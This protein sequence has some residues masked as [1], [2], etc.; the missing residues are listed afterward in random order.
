MDDLAKSFDFHRRF[1][2]LE[3]QKSRTPEKFKGEHQLV[4]G[5]SRHNAAKGKLKAK[6]KEVRCA[7]A[8]STEHHKKVANKFNCFIALFLHELMYY[9]FVICHHLATDKQ[10]VQLSLNLKK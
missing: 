9:Y 4:K 5:K 8:Y 6:T 2:S 10:Q 7:S 3:A 1:P